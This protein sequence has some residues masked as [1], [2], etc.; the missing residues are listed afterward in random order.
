[1]SHTIKALKYEVG[2]MAPAS[3]LCVRITSHTAA[4]TTLAY[5][6]ESRASI[7]GLSGWGNEG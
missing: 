2:V 4:S 1:V 7:V 3:F 6:P 5:S